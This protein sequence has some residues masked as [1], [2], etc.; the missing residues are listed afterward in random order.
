[1]DFFLMEREARM[2]ERVMTGY[3]CDDGTMRDNTQDSIH[4]KRYRSNF[5]A[6]PGALNGRAKLTQVDVLNIRH[7]YRHGC[8]QARLAAAYGVVQPHISRLVREESY[9]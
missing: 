4:K 5:R 1:M 2:W 8:T 3:R 6:M 7:L 9:K